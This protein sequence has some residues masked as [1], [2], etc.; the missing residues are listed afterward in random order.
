[1]CKSSNSRNLEYITLWLIQ[2]HNIDK[3][4]LK[5]KEDQSKPVSCESQAGTAEQTMK[6]KMKALGDTGAHSFVP[7]CGINRQ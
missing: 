5:L 1:M 3:L 6:A 4:K 7:K 2:A